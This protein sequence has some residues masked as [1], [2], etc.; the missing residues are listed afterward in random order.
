[1]R[2]RGLEPPRLAAPDPKSGASASSATPAKKVVRPPGL[3]P[4][5]YG[6]EG[7]CSIQLS[8][9]RIEASGT[10]ERS[11][12]SNLRIR[13]PLLYPIEL[14]AHI[15]AHR[16]EHKFFYY[17]GLSYHMGWMTGLEPATPRATIWCSNHLSYTHHLWKKTIFMV[18]AEGFEPPTPWSQTRC[19]NQTAL[20]P[21]V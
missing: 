8:Y 17:H 12:T 4:G 15:S 3:E 19:A 18:G 20:R 5:T 9:E 7:R 16:L 2:E 21:A 13:S 11:R 1:M 6:L 14:R 10:P